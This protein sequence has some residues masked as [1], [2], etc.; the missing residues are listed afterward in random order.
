MEWKISSE[1]VEQIE[2]ETEARRRKTIINS[3]QCFTLS[4]FTVINVVA[5]PSTIHCSFK[6]SLKRTLHNNDFNFHSSTFPDYER[7]A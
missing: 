7:L 2:R 5:K 1:H 4:I 6:D 3:T